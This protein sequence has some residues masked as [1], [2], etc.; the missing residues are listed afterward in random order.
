[1][2]KIQVSAGDPYGRL[3]VV[4]EAP[5]KQYPSGTRRA[6]ICKCECGNVVTALLSDLRDEHTTSCGCRQRECCAQMKLSHGQHAS[7]AYTSWNGMLQRCHNPDNPSYAR[8]GA[9][10][11]VVCDR[12]RSSFADFLKDMGHRPDGFSIERVD[13]E[14]P[15]SPENCVWASSLTQNRNKRSN[16]M[17]TYQ[18]VTR[19]ASEWAS[20]LGIP[21]QTLYSRLARGWPIEKA[22]RNF[23]RRG[24][25]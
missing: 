13:N 11:I 18:G 20:V 24:R 1:M 15:Y 8:Y 25:S 12:W 14:G 23:K 6:F 10:G 7:L 9:R 19:A 4:S 16:V 17:L 5:P 2:K 22:L 3:T 21:P